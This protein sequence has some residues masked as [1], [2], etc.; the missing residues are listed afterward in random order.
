[1]VHNTDSKYGR[2]LS[3]IHNHPTLKITMFA[4]GVGDGVERS[5]LETIASEPSCI[6]VF[7][8][9]TFADMNH[10]KTQLEKTTCGSAID[11]TAAHVCWGSPCP[12]SSLLRYLY[13]GELGKPL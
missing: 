2:L 6:H 10:F 8:L 1:M 9:E 4:V 3:Q 11:Y 7:M 13:E 5:E 12:T